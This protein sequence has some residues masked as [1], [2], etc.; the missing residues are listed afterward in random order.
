VNRR[1][2]EDSA[3]IARHADLRFYREL[4]RSGVRR[5]P[6]VEYTKYSDMLTRQ[7][8]RAIRGECTPIEA[9]RRAEADIAADQS[10]QE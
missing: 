3:L 1:V 5:P 4:L 9:L 8:K 7:L 10:A 2:Y 6:L